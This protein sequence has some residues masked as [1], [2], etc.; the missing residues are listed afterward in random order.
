[1]T[2]SETAADRRRPLTMAKLLVYQAYRGDVD[3]WARRGGGEGMTGDDWQLIER[4]RQDLFL[5]AA[6][7]SS[8]E[9]AA[10]TERRLRD[11]TDGEQTREALRE[12]ARAHPV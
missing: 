5:V 11:A 12:L 6:G 1:M 7:R 8:P 9:F 4:L 2:A 10:A 3:G